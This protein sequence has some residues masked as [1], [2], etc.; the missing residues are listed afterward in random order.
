MAKKFNNGFEVTAYEPIDVRI[1]LTKEQM[2]T[3]IGDDNSGDVPG[4]FTMPDVYFAF[5]VDDGQFYKFDYEADMDPETG[6]FRKLELGGSTPASGSGSTSDMYAAL[7]NA[8]AGDLWYNTD[9][10]K[11][12][13][14]AVDS[15]GNK[16][17]AEKHPE[18]GE[19]MYDEEAGKLMYFDGNGWKEVGA[20]ATQTAT[21]G[22]TAPSDANQGDQ[23]LDT[24]TTPPTL[25][26]LGEDGQW[27]EVTPKAGEMM[28]DATED[29]VMYFDGTEWKPIGGG[30][31]HQPSVD[32][33]SIGTPGDIVYD[34]SSN[35]FKTFEP[36][37][38]GDT[39]DVWLKMAK[40][41]E[42]TTAEYN[43]LNSAGGD[44]WS[45][46]HPDVICFIKD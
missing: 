37:K 29:V 10:G 31:E 18:P 14:C 44:A 13:Y 41:W 34:E 22:T 9:D 25:K 4:D 2:S 12:Y 1:V 16:S 23:W 32:P 8:S 7:D 21:S 26:E 45:V 24:S 36:K 11:V 42:G 15:E 6:K 30:V 19:M 20:G 46:N 40:V 3:I 5:C 17:W 27:D 43:A 38:S 35:E 28:Y 39:K 33:T